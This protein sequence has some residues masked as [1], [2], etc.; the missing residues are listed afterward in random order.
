M[1][2]RKTIKFTL[3]NEVVFRLEVQ[4]SDDIVD[5]LTSD[6]WFNSALRNAA[7]S[8]IKNRVTQNTTQTIKPIKVEK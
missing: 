8:L 1:S 6:L 7:E 2:K 3:D 5:K 4:G